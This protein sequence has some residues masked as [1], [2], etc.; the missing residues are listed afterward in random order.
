MD[1]RIKK[2][3]NKCTLL[4]NNPLAKSPKGTIEDIYAFINTRYVKKQ[5]SIGS[6]YFEKTYGKK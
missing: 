6:N 3:T 2:V 1:F 5:A 4:Y